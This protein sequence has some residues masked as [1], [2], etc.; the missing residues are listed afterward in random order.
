MG[1]NLGYLKGQTPLDEDESEGLLIPTIAT[2]QELDDFE[3]LNIEN[4]FQWVLN[5]SFKKEQILT[6]KFVL[7]VHSRMFGDVWQWAGSFRKTEKNLGIKAWK[8]PTALKVLLE[9]TAY[10][11]S[12]ET[13]EPDEIAIRFKHR[14]VS[15]H[16]F[17]NGNGRHSRLMADII[18]YHI[19]KLQMFTWGMSH[20]FQKGD[21]RSIY[22][23]ALKMADN[24]D[25]QPLLKFAR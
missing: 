3:Q 20:L 22:L 10:W 2:R 11:M 4:A 25:Y 18:I 14:L 24:G 21:A 6:E 5:K 17:S 1:L 19:Y 7:E 15:I 12:H 23:K 16:C 8:I 9:D 13:F